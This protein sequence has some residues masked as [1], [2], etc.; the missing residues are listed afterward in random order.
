MPYTLFSCKEGYKY[1]TFTDWQEFVI[2][3]ND[4]Y[5]YCKNL[6]NFMEGTDIVN[7]IS[8]LP[9]H[10]PYWG[11]SVAK[12]N[13]EVELPRIEGVIQKINELKEI[14]KY[15]HLNVG[16]ITGNPVLY[17]ENYFLNRKQQI[18]DDYKKYYIG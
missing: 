13:I 2:A 7:C 3:S 10:H 4:D 6:T 8:E 9:S 15:N 5:Q 18:L 1:L 14:G 11:Y 17:G 12:H 16:L